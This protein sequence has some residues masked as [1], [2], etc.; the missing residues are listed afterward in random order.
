MSLILQWEAG[1]FLDTMKSGR[2]HPM[3]INCY[4]NTDKGIVRKDFVVKAFGLNE[5]TEISLFCEILGL[6]IAQRLNIP[7]PDPGLIN[8]DE[9]FLNI[10][11]DDFAKRNISLATGIAVGTELLRGMATV[12]IA[13]SLSDQQQDDAKTLYA[14]DLL[15][16]NPDRSVRNPNCG[17]YNN[18][19]I[20]YDFECAFS[21]LRLLFIV[22]ESWEISKHG[23]NEKHLFYS[24]L[25]KMDINWSEFCQLVAKLDMD[26][27]CSCIDSLPS[28]WCVKSK[29]LITHLESIIMNVDKLDLELRRSL[30]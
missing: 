10:N 13:L 26:Y 19:I 2:T 7:V 1:R 5:I 16:Q 21:F 11:K 24:L 6:I 20:A 14:T 29:M 30:A 9:A 22:D 17:L 18:R 3:I 8:I 23:I 25:H 4:R 27:V 15:L 28:S 12:N